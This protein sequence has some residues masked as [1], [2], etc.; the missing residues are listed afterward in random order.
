MDTF[1]RLRGGFP[2]WPIEK[3]RDLLWLGDRVV[4]M[5]GDD[6]VL[7]YRWPV[8]YAVLALAGVIALWRRYRFGALLLLGPFSACLLAAVAQ[9]YP[10]R[11]RVALYILPA[12]V[13]C[14]AQAAETI[15]ALLARVHPALGAA[16]LAA[17]FL[18]PA[19]ASIEFPPPYRVEDH[20]RMLA[21]VRDHFQPGDAVFV[22]A[23]ETEALE[24]YGAAYGLPE[25]AYDVGGC[26][27]EDRRVFLRDADRYRGRPG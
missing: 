24:R 18:G 26:S 4:E 14:V 1:W 16:A 21:F 2:P 19:V 20:K 15:R 12:L 11:T 13:L 25:S 27:D 7:K 10:F 8:V 5:L 9:Q 3:P 6:M 22:Y 23:Y 17:V